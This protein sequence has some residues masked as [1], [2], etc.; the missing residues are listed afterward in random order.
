ME[1]RLAILGRDLLRVVQR[2]ERTDARAAK[3]RVVQEHARDDERAGE[4]A[5]TCFVGTRDEAHS[6]LPVVGKEALAARARHAAEDRW[7]GGR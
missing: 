3:L 2:R 4:G 6:E 5:A 7:C 1:Q